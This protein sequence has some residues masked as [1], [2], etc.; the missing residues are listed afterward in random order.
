LKFTLK[1]LQVFLEVAAQGSALA[2]SKKLMISQPAVSASLVELEKNLATTLFHRRKKRIILNEMGRDLVPIAKLLI[3]KA[4]DLD[5]MFQDCEGSPQ[6]TLRVGASTTPASYILP[7][8]I[9]SF[10]EENPQVRIDTFSRNKTGIVSLFED[11]SLDIGV[12]AGSSHKPHVK[13]IPWIVDDLC[14]FASATHPLT[15]KKDVSLAD[16]I[17][18]YW[19]TR[20]EGS[21]TLEVFIKALSKSAGSLKTL[22]VFDNLESIKRAV[23]NTSTLGCTSP[24]AIQREIKMGVLKII[25]TPFLNLRREYSFLVHKERHQSQL[26]NYFIGHCFAQS[27]NMGSF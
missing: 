8:L 20:E 19:V 25:P 21:G 2:A 16:L 11:F 1:Q 13:N 22:L 27:K 4:N 23:E 17:D 3:A 5:K 9:S 15:R 14:V 12:I 10:V 24:Y 7:S 6:G 26:L 18:C